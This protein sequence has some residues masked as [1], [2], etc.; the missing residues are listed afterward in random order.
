MTLADFINTSEGV[1][2]IALYEYEEFDHPICYTRSDW[3]GVAPYM[4]REIGYFEITD[5]PR[6]NMSQVNIHFMDTWNGKE[7][8]EPFEEQKGD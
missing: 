1:Y 4:G 6:S 5:D 3:K 7:N 2:R 8:K